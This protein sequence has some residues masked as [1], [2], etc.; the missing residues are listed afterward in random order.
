MLLVAVSDVDVEGD[1]AGDVGIVDVG[2]GVADVDDDSDDDDDG[3][4]DD[5]GGDDDDDEQ[6]PPLGDVLDDGAP[7]PA[8]SDALGEVADALGEGLADDSVG[9]GD[10]LAAVVDAGETGGG[11]AAGGPGSTG[12]SVV[13][14]G[15]WAGTSTGA[16]MPAV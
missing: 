15:G 6:A 7:E 8:D 10:R 3:N 2:V 16:T 11:A 12:G 14:M 5:D 9:W 1:G 13:T 4:G